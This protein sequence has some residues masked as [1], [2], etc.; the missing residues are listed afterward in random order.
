MR[1]ETAVWYLERLKAFRANVAYAEKKYGITYDVFL[2]LIE[3]IKKALGV[4]TEDEVIAKLETIAQ[5]NLYTKNIPD[6][7]EL[8]LWQEELEKARKQ[9]S[10]ITKDINKIIKAYIDFR[11][12]RYKEAIE[13]QTRDVEQS[14]IEETPALKG[15]PVLAREVTGSIQAVII[16]RAKERYGPDHPALN[17]QA[18]QTIVEET[19]EEVNQLLKEAGVFLPPDKIQVFLEKYSQPILN[20]YSL[21]YLQGAPII[22]YETK[23]K[24]PAVPL[25]GPI[26]PQK[27]PE[28]P[29][30][31]LVVQEGVVRITTEEQNTAFST[32]Y[33]LS[34][35]SLV[36]SFTKKLALS[37]VVKTLQFLD[38]LASDELKGNAAQTW[39]EKLHQGLTSEDLDASIKTL[40]ETG[41]ESNNPQLISLIEKRLEVTA[42]EQRHPFISNLLRHYHEFSKVSGKRQIT[43]LD[44]S[45]TL[46]ALAT[47]PIW[48]TRVPQP[49]HFAIE[50]RNFFNKVGIALHFFE[51]ETTT[52]GSPKI[53]FALP[54]KIISV[55][56]FGKIKNL[57]AI[58]QGSGKVIYII[59]GATKGKIAKSALGLAIKRGSAALITKLGLAAIPTGVTQV[60]A[61][62]WI[63]KDIIGLLGGLLKSL[64]KKPSR[65]IFIGIA[66]FSIP[67]LIPLTPA[68]TALALGLGALSLASGLLSSAKAFVG[69]L[70]AGAGNAIGGVINGLGG[71]LSSLGSF[72]IPSIVYAAPVVATGGVGV[73]TA[74]VILN[75]SA[76]FLKEPSTHVGTPTPYGACSLTSD[77]PGS[78]TLKETM[79]SAS[80]WAGI[81]PGILAA[82]VSIEGEHLFRYSDEQI[83]Q[84]SSPGTSDPTSCPS[85][86]PEG[87]ECYAKGPMQFTTKTTFAPFCGNGILVYDTWNKYKDAVNRALPSEQRTPNV[88]NIKDSIYAA[89][90]MIKTLSGTDEKQTCIWDK[91]VI[92]KVGAGYYGSCDEKISRYGGK[93]YCEVVFDYYQARNLAQNINPSN[94]FYYQGDSKWNPPLAVYNTSYGTIS[95]AGCGP[96]SL[97]MVLTYYGT[98]KTPVEMWNEVISRGYMTRDGLAWTAI[99]SMPASYGLKV[100]NL[101][102]SWSLAENEIK[103]GSLVI[104]STDLFYVGHILVIRQINDNNI[105]TNDPG[106]SNGDGY[107]AYNKQNI[108][109]RNLWAVSN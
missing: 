3:K 31:E 47:P 24:T 102:T 27:P 58:R 99:S 81:P 54:G 78:T 80:Q 65:L 87:N 76:S 28:T 103:K 18:R 20:E 79:I 37:P 4:Q 64:V 50:T 59:I 29:K 74:V 101:G 38:L 77:T 42:Y 93:T 70:L 85:N 23:E 73:L 41:I 15:D 1:P 5:G 40:T 97:A 19:S 7:Y 94:W 107:S 95:L 109:M 88:C 22:L 10:T 68:L 36:L 32:F 48:S 104:A 71:F 12:K 69:N 62:L 8:R 92:D 75:I 52:Y 13:K 82:I 11:V 17:E 14:F 9:E 86:R 55:V 33:A 60:A 25:A 51:I 21:V 26:Q 84:Y 39:R 45:Q 100:Q 35:P 96:T 43:L 105:V 83:K 49:N 106:R 44:S 66:F 6:Q 98:P 34:Q 63:G 16:E 67:L 30:P 2:D 56:T 91:G 90:W 57:K 61:V 72:P 89:A 108:L 46:P 53:V